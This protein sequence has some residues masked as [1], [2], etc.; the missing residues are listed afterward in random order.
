VAFPLVTIA[1]GE[2]IHRLQRQGNHL[3][4]TARAIRH[5]V[6]PALA[7]A[8]FAR[9]VLRV[10]SGTW[11]QILDTLVW[12]CA[13]NA[14]LSLV[15]VVLFRHAQESTWRGRVPR[16]FLDLTRFLLVVVGGTLVL[17]AVWERDIGGIMTALGVGTV[18]IGLAL[19]ETLGSIVSGVALLF[20]RPFAEGDWIRVGDTVGRVA[21]MNW[22]SVR[23]RTFDDDIAT[24]PHLVIAK[25]MILNYTE[26]AKLHVE[27]IAVGFSYNDAPNLVKR[28]MLEI[29]RTTE[30]VLSDPPPQVMTLSYDDFSI[31]YEVWVYIADYGRLLEIRDDFTTRVWY[32]AKRAGLTIPFPIRTVHNYDGEKLATDAYAAHLAEGLSAANVLLP[33]ETDGAAAA[34]MDA[35]I[36]HFGA[37]E[38]IIRVGDDGGTLYLIVAGRARMTIGDP[39]DEHVVLTLGRSEFF[40]ELALHYGGSSPVSV[41]ATEDVELVALSSDAVQQMIATRPTLAR[42]VNDIAEA[43]TRAIE[44]VQRLGA[45]GER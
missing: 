11:T 36:L 13:I 25:E 6:A 10:E 43:R 27:R 33:S 8:L 30:G 7:L 40:G 42:E 45:R 21:E 32:A 5:S 16:L 17:A 1:L 15:N 44:S 37:G 23:L 35:A 4:A 38:Y 9:H 29:A 39:G 24:I 12:V 14:A 22:R 41:V 20:E 19:Q 26:P 34:G 2:L 3:E 18:V 28:T 31:A